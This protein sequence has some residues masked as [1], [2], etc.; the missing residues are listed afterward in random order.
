MQFLKHITI[1]RLTAGFTVLVVGMGIASVFSEAL[2]EPPKPL[3][4]KRFMGDH[5][6]SKSQSV[7]MSREE[8]IAF[9]LSD[10]ASEHQGDAR[11]LLENMSNEMLESGVHDLRQ[12]MQKR[13]P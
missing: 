13:Q 11:L 10:V 8:M 4:I 12:I 3:T 2:S 6:S 1:P 5:S 9:L 7:S